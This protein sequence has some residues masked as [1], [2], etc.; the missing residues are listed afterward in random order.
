MKYIVEGFWG[1]G[2]T[3]LLS[4]QYNQGAIFSEPHHQEY[5]STQDQE[6]ISQWY[7]DTHRHRFTEFTLMQGNAILERSILS[8]MA[9]QHACKNQI[10]LASWQAYIEDMQDYQTNKRLLIIVLYTDY[11]LLPSHVQQAYS[12]EFFARYMDFYRVQLPYV[13]GIVPSFIKVHDEDGEYLTEEAIDRQIQ[14]IYRHDRIGQ[15]NIV[16]YR[17]SHHT[18]EFL[19]LQR[20]PQKGSFWQSITGGIHM[21]GSL[22]DNALREL[23]EELSLD[24]NPECLRQAEYVFWYCGGEGYELTEY[25]FGY[26]IHSEDSLVLSDEHVACQYLPYQEAIEKVKYE[27]NKQA[28]LTV[29]KE[30]SEEENRLS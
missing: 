9:F 5:I 17:I 13:F 30:I 6:E 23:R 19:V 21:Q 11:H 2:K 26:E 25:V 4:S 1:V 14:A 20:N 24:G 15:I 27:G 10:S 29:Y 22:Q 12:Q 7:I 28:I 18:P 8:S 16:P 3:T